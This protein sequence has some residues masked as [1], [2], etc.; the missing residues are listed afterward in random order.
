MHASDLRPFPLL[1]HGAY[2]CFDRAPAA[3]PRRALANEFLAGCDH[4]GTTIAYLRRVGATPADLADDPLLRATAIVHVASP[5]REPIDELC[6]ELAPA[7]VLRGV[8]RP[9]RYTSDVIHDFAYAHRVLPQP[10]AA[11]PEAFLLP[12]SKTDAWWSKDRLERHGYFLPRYDD[13]GRMIIEG[14][15]LAARAGIPCL[16]RRTYRHEDCRAP[17]GDYDFLTYFECATADVATF[18]AV[19]GA[20]R[21]V[22]RN[23]EWRFVREG[24]MWH[25]RRVATWDE[26][27]S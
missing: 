1:R 26:L 13:D 7:R 15:A 3:P 17:A 6:G 25:G 16:L 21:D 23:P 12:M 14:H 2:L 22:A 24:P 10:G 9:P 5:D 27:R 18:H 11:M 8:V 4:A 20:L 19:C